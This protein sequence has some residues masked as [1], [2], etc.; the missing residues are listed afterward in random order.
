MITLLP[1]LLSNTALS[2]FSTLESRVLS[3]FTIQDFAQ[4][5]PQTE[6]HSDF[7]TLLSE[8]FVL[9]TLTHIPD[10]T[11]YKKISL[12]LQNYLRY[13]FYAFLRHSFITL[14][15]QFSGCFKFSIYFYCFSIGRPRV[16]Q[17]IFY[18]C[19]PRC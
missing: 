13:F 6:I 16:C 4:T 10:I 12:I 15:L 11:F 9:R 3:F 14:S 1:L 8:K 5:I 19:I 2:L 18:S 17:T 7:P